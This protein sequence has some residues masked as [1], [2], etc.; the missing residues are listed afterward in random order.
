VYQRSGTHR[1]GLNCNKQLAVPKA[2]VT[3]RGTRFAQGNYFRVSRWIVVGQVAVPP[4]S[5][6]VSV[7][8]H[9][10]AHWDFAYGQ[11]PLGGSQ[12]FFHPEFIGHNRG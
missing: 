9:D 8:H 5:Y 12:C 11:R 2:M 4:A 10:G 3:N 7:A 6:D 1:T